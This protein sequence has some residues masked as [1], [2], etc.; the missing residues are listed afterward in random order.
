MFPYASQFSS[1]FAPADA[2][3]CEIVGEFVKNSS[4]HLM[5]TFSMYGCMLVCYGLFTYM[6]T[7]T[8]IGPF[9]W[10]KFPKSIYG[11]S[12]VT[13]K[14][15]TAEKRGQIPMPQGQISVPKWLL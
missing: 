12:Y 14:V 15:H 6:E 13:K 11:Y 10:G 5:L 1:L 3:K 8:G 9:C 4:G 2:S 7:V